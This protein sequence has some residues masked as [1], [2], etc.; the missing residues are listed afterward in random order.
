MLVE[1]DLRAES[2]ILAEPVT[3]WR[4]WTLYARKRGAEV[5]LRPIGGRARPWPPFEPARATCS[6][7]GRYPVP[8]FDCTCG[9]HATRSSDLL[10]R[11]RNPAVLGTVA[12]W[13]R[14]VEHEHGYR[15]AFAYPQ[16]LMLVCHL[17]FWQWGPERSSPDAVA[18]LRGGR[19][20]PLCDGHVELS[21]RY[22]YPTRHLV[23]VQGIEGALLSTY[24]VDPLRL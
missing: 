15:A 9:L 14:V 24:A 19:L 16:R 5:R 11:A 6:R 8:G 12:L 22:G 10:R 18:V 4:V 2:R 1:T 17:C 21:D 20:V 13:G 7:H 23:P 3:G